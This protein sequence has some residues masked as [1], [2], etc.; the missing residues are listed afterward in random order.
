MKLGG[1]AAKRVKGSVKRAK[2]AQRCCGR[3]RGDQPW[4]E[5]RDR[6]CRRN[7]TV[8]PVKGDSG[9]GAGGG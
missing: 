4:E 1:T 3:A 2:P 7:R 6:R 5:K 9:D 8:V